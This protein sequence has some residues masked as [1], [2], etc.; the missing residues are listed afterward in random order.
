MANQVLFT[1]G[2]C[3]G[4]IYIRNAFTRVAFDKSA[5]V[6]NTYVWGNDAENIDARDTCAKNAYSARGIC[7]KDVD[8]SSICSSA[9][10]F[11]QSSV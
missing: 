7:I 5:C 11:S 8:T 3:T 9:H 2:A 10:K 4:S 1:F 6:G